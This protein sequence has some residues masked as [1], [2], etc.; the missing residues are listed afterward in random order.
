MFVEVFPYCRRL[1]ADRRPDAIRL[2][3]IPAW[4]KEHKVET[5]MHAVCEEQK[6][7]FPFLDVS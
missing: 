6:T 5:E 3:F 4:N 2:A 1:E 7:L